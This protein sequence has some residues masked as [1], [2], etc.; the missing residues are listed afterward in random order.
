MYWQVQEYRSTSRGTV[1]RI[2]PEE[3]GHSGTRLQ[4]P[5][6]W[7]TPL[8]AK[9][10]RQERPH[11]PSRVLHSY[12]LLG[13][14][15]KP[16]QLVLFSAKDH[17]IY[18]VF[19]KVFMIL[20]KGVPSFEP[21]PNG[22]AKN[23][24]T[25][26]HRIGPRWSDGRPG[27][28]HVHT[29][30][31]KAAIFSGSVAQ[32]VFPRLNRAGAAG[33]YRINNDRYYCAFPQAGVAYLQLSNFST[34]GQAYHLPQ[35]KQNGNI[36]RFWNLN[37]PRSWSSFSGQWRDQPDGLSG[38]VP[39]FRRAGSAKGVQLL[40]AG[41]HFFWFLGKSLDNL[42]KGKNTWDTT[43]ATALFSDVLGPDP[44]QHV[45]SKLSDGL[46]NGGPKGWVTFQLQGNH[47]NYIKFKTTRWGL[48]RSFNKPCRWIFGWTLDLRLIW[49]LVWRPG[50]T[51]RP[52]MKIHSQMNIRLD[53]S[54]RLTVNLHAKLSLAKP[55]VLRQIPWPAR[56]KTLEELIGFPKGVLH[57][58]HMLRDRHQ[59]P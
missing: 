38:Y 24:R 26:I 58:S 23:G 17:K 18:P 19:Y 45:W 20:K 33:I 11:H 49:T 55:W 43:D 27:P 35:K 21:Y 4:W 53:L 48:R 34:F 59:G 1:G 13:Q 15:L 57:Y 5:A 47:Q 54:C 16:Q 52:G 51:V 7:P 46:R 42:E 28:P 37:S 32:Q 14:H 3:K 50:F 22:W 31:S 41:D 12:Q 36:K 40:V 44:V 25:E 9:A 8:P 10:H 29:K 39:K 30:A 6:P 2:S 56:L